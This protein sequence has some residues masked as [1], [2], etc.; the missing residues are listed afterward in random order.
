MNFGSVGIVIRKF[1]K[2]YFLFDSWLLPF[3]IIIY[4]NNLKK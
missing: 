4:S 3:K 1:V 2:K